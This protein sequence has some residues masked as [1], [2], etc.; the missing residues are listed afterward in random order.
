MP[1]K[2]LVCPL[3]PDVVE[4]VIGQ[5][6]LGDVLT[7]L[8]GLAEL[9]TSSE[10]V[11]SATRPPLRLRRPWNAPTRVSCGDLRGRLAEKTPKASNPLQAGTQGRRENP[12]CP[13]S[14]RI[15]TGYG[16]PRIATASAAG[17]DRARREG[18]WGDISGRPLR[19]SISADE[20]S[21]RENRTQI[22]SDPLWVTLPRI[23]RPPSLALGSGKTTSTD[24]CIPG[25]DPSRNTP[26]RQIFLVWT[27]TRLPASVTSQASVRTQMQSSSWSSIVTFSNSRN[28]APGPEP[29][30]RLTR[31]T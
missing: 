12:G 15:C 22:P 16:A 7:A 19:I 31:L 28:V 8:D 18:G 17:R 11:A 26:L 6:S 20:R 1:C 4:K 29:K 23:R 27:L 14:Q 13:G 2:A 24:S 21:S 30:P 10:Q 9:F 5:K 25:H 3:S